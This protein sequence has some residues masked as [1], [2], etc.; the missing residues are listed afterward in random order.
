M[1]LISWGRGVKYK[2]MN[3]YIQIFFYVLVLLFIVFTLCY[4]AHQY[5][6]LRISIVVLATLPTYYIFLKILVEWRML[7]V[8]CCCADTP[9]GTPDF[10]ISS[11]QLTGCLKDV[12]WVSW[13][14]RGNIMSWPKLFFDS[15]CSDSLSGTSKS[16]S[17][18]TSSRQP[19]QNP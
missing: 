10:D 8:D 4:W 12:Y 16:D 13:W 11:D 3:F 5:F 6:K 19:K 18:S 9:S 2:N 7:T 17:R 14:A 1:Q 15:G